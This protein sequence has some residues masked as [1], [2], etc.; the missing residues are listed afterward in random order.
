MDNH[1]RDDREKTLTLISHMLNRSMSIR[2]LLQ[3]IGT[4]VFRNR[5]N[6]QI[7]INKLK[8]V[9]LEAQSRSLNIVIDD[10][11]FPNERQL[12]R[13]LGFQLWFIDRPNKE[14]LNKEVID[15]ASENQLDD[16]Y[17]EAITNDGT[18]EDLIT[19]I[20]HQIRNL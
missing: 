18:L 3:V 8:S 9:I 16:C 13:N 2:S 12:L 1:A 5:I 10:A 20:D 15:H 17:D 6:E 7:W 11:R 19:K 14:V 4:Q